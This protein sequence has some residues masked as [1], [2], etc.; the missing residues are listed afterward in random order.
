MKYQKT[1][2]RIKNIFYTVET[3][4]FIENNEITSREKSLNC[5]N[6]LLKA[7]VQGKHRKA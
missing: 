7:R 3:S 2:K 4:Q 5:S 1:K 6:E